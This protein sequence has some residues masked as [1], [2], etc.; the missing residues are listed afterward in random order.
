[1]G[2]KTGG[3]VH[4]LSEGGVTATHGVTAPHSI[5]V[6]PSTAH[7][8]NTIQ[9]DL[10]PIACCSLYDNRFEFDSSF[11]RPEAAR[12]FA[13]LASLRKAHPGAP[14]SI[15]GHADPVGTEAYNKQLS[16]RRAEA[17]YGLL[18]RTVSIW[19]R[20]F[21]QPIQPF[22][23]DNWGLRSVQVMLDALL[24]DPQ[25]F[26][27]VMDKQTREALQEFQREHGLPPTGNVGPRTRPKLFLAY[28]DVLCR[29]NRPSVP[30]ANADVSRPDVSS[31]PYTLTKQDF[32]ARGA[33]PH[34]R[35]DYQACSDFNPLL[36]FSQSEEA[37]FERAQDKKE[38]NDANAPNRRVLLYLFRPGTELNLAQWPCPSAANKEVTDCHRRFWSDSARRLS[39]QPPRREYAK[40]RDTFACRFYDRLAGESPCESLR[41]VIVKT[42]IRI[43]VVDSRTGAVLPNIA[44]M[45]RSATG[46][47]TPAVTDE[48]GAVL[49]E[50]LDPGPVEVSS[51]SGR[52][53]FTSDTLFFVGTGELP[54]GNVVAAATPKGGQAPTAA[55]KF[56]K[57]ST[58][59]ARRFIAEIARDATLGT[60]QASSDGRKTRPFKQSG[61]ASEEIHV[62]RVANAF[63]FSLVDE[64]GFAI[65][66]AE[67]EI[68]LADL[69]VRIGRLDR[70]GQA[71]VLDAPDGAFELRYVDPDDVKAKS[72]AGRARKA[73][74]AEDFDEILSLLTYSPELLAAAVAV[75]AR[76]FNDLS[77]KGMPED[78]QNAVKDE[79]RNLLIQMLLARSGLPTR[80]Q[81]KYR[82]FDEAE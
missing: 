54:Q 43:I 8:F 53:E 62:I 69:S 66:E 35:G 77:G 1:M 56:V 67:F 42:W 82:K 3:L 75:Y 11:I 25:R 12:E 32:L 19:E 65:P 71:T 44:L 30:Q 41:P 37:N 48:S 78:I 31:Q 55:A 10:R 38:R 4:E 14:I 59:T 23:S 57:S 20:L 28:M 15:F 34:G 21:T 52:E 68:T 18:T 50:G 70:D 13:F 27:G 79:S 81:I 46:A 73:C 33:H 17:V 16:G 29:E 58:P 64:N 40:T 80:Q 5:L 51:D 39:A 47:E 45:V 76:F 60:Q 2:D 36:I 26:D 22:N 63:F 24:H 72:L 7:Q 74:A 61:L 6:G 9:P 49:V